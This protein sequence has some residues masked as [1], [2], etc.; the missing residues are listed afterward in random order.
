MSMPLSNKTFEKAVLN[1][2]ALL[3]DLASMPS[4][5]LDSGDLPKQK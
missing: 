3:G 5:G 2:D 1:F 4:V